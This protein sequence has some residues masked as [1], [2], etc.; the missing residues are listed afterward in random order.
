M[1]NIIINSIL[2]LAGLTLGSKMSLAQCPADGIFITEFVYDVCNDSD[3]GDGSAGTSGW[4]EYIVLTNTS[5]ASIDIQNGEFDDDGD[6]T[7]GNGTIISPGS[8]LNIPAGGCLIISANTQANWESEY[9]LVSA[10]TCLYYD[11]SIE[12]FQSLNNGGDNIAFSGACNNGSYTDVAAQGEVVIWDG[13]AFVLGGVVSIHASCGPQTYV[14]GTAGSSSSCPDLSGIVA[15]DF[16]PV[17]TNSACEM[18]GVTV[19]GGS[20]AA[21]ATSPCPAGSQ[22]QYSTD[23]GTTFVND[24]PTYN[25]TSSVSFKMRCNCETDENTFSAEADFATSPGVCATCPAGLVSLTANAVVV[26]S[27]STCEADGVTLSGGVIAAAATNCPPE[28]TLE[29]SVDGGSNW[30]TSLPTYNQTTA[31]TILTRCN[32][33][34]DNSVSSAQ[35]SVLTDPGTCPSTLCTLPVVTVVAKCTNDSGATDI[36]AGEDMFFIQ[37]TISDLGSDSDGDNEVTVTVA[38]AQT[39]Y[40][41]T[42]TYYVG[43]YNHSGT[44]TTTIP[45]SYENDGESCSDTF[46]VSEVICGFSADGD[47]NSDGSEDDD[48]HASGP[49][50]DCNEDPMGWILAQVAPGSF[51]ASSSVMIYIL[52]DAN[53]DVVE[54]NNTG[55]FEGLTNQAYNIYP[56]NVSTDDVMI[57]EAAIPASGDPYTGFTPP[58][59]ACSAGCGSAPMVLECRC[60]D[61]AI[62]KVVSTTG[63]LAVG[64]DVTFTITVLNQG[65]SDIYNVVVAD[66]LP[67][68][69]DFFQVENAGNAFASN[70]DTPGGGTV[71]ATVAT[72]TPIAPGGSLPLTII[73]KINNTAGSMASLTNEAEITGASQD[74]ANTMPIND[75]DD[76]LAATGGGTEDDNNVDDGGMD[77][78]DDQDDF[79]FAVVS[80]CSMPVAPTVVGAS[81][82]LNEVIAALE[83]TGVTGAFFSFYADS[84][85][86]VLLATG[87]T[88]TPTGAGTFFVTQ[89]DPLGCEGP[90][91]EVQIIVRNTNCGSFPWNGTRTN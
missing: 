71:T 13:S 78:P 91:T 16:V 25:Q 37:I 81:Y 14:P 43:P 32:C 54:Y 68:G 44:G 84:G 77:D 66:Y 12:G 6:V 65:N 10:T 73:L 83:P 35:G 36:E 85:L 38:G 90:A 70:T 47:Q 57:F 4:G 55:K 7:N 21:P 18:D 76:A 61:V 75:E 64:S 50:C 72:S 62:M 17:I 69:L 33:D 1:K 74:A 67:S 87:A 41:A 53:G 23:G 20:I 80:L 3:L 89:T 28:T 34:A 86:Q 40:N 58:S 39:T 29:Y 51:D 30:N 52:A 82:C 22:L 56:Y 45:V 2:L 26:S 49:A 42:G 59:G 63:A 19:S 88:Y 46:V 11:A 8:A 15:G 60:D 5:S 48:L 9:G 24:V 31:E 79:D 27:E